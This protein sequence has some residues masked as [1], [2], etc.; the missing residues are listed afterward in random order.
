MVNTNFKKVISSILTISFLATYVFFQSPASAQS[1]QPVSIPSP[2][3]ISKIIVNSG[4]ASLEEQFSG[5]EGPKGRIVIAIQD[6]HGIFQAQENIRAVIQE[7][8]EKYHFNLVGLEGGAGKS[9]HIFLRAFPDKDASR[10]QTVKFMKR[11]ELSGGEAAAILNP[12]PGIFYG[13]ENRDL[14]FQN[15]ASFLKAMEAR[16][17]NLH[18]IRMEEKKLEKQASEIFPTE[19]YRFHQAEQKY[20]NGR[21]LFLEWLGILAGHAGVLRA[22]KYPNSFKLFEAIAKARKAGEKKPEVE[23]EIEDVTA[24]IEGRV[25]FEELNAM[26]GE[27]KNSFVAAT[28]VANN[29]AIEIATTVVATSVANNQAIEIATT[30]QQF[31]HLHL[32][33]NLISLQLTRAE[34][35]KFPEMDSRLRGNDNLNLTPALNFYVDA[36]KRD[37][38]LYENLMQAMKKENQK[39]SIIVAGG[40][41]TQGLA[42]RLK[43]EGISFAVYSPRIHEF[44]KE[45]N[46]FDVMQGKTSYSSLQAVLISMGLAD[47]VSVETF[48]KAFGLGAF[49]LLIVSQKI[50]SIKGLEAAGREWRE[51]IIKLS[52]NRTKLRDP[53]A[54]IRLAE[55]IV[56]TAAE[57]KLGRGRTEQILSIL[58][59]VFTRTLSDE[60]REKVNRFIAA[61]RTKLQ[62]KQK[63]NPEDI[64]EAVIR[65]SE[66]VVAASTSITR[67]ASLG[68]SAQSINAFHEAFKKENL[69]YE[70]RVALAENYKAPRRVRLEKEWNSWI[71][72]LKGKDSKGKEIYY[73]SA[74]IEIPP[75]SDSMALVFNLRGQKANALEFKPGEQRVTTEIRKFLVRVGAIIRDDAARRQLLLFPEP[76]QTDLPVLPKPST[77]VRGASLGV[78]PATRF[79][80][81]EWVEMPLNH[82]GHVNLRKL[83]VPDAGELPK[84]DALKQEIRKYIETY[85]KP[86][87]GLPQDINLERQAKYEAALRNLDH[88][89]LLPYMEEARRYNILLVVSRK[90]TDFKEKFIPYLRALTKIFRQIPP[91]M[92]WELA[93]PTGWEIAKTDKYSMGFQ[94]KADTWAGGGAGMTVFG[95]K[96]EELDI[97]LERVG[98]MEDLERTVGGEVRY[99][100][101]QLRKT[102]VHELLGHKRSITKKP[103]YQITGNRIRRVPKKWTLAMPRSAWQAIARVNG[104]QRI[105]IAPLQ[106]Y[107]KIEDIP[108]NPQE[109]LNL[110]RRIDE[111]PHTYYSDPLEL[112]ARSAEDDDL[113]HPHRRGAGD[114]TEVRNKRHDLARSREILAVSSA[115]IGIPVDV[116][117]KIFASWMFDAGGAE[118][119]NPYRIQYF[120]QSGPV[121]APVWQR[122]IFE[123][124]VWKI[125][126]KPV[127]LEAL[128]KAKQAPRPATAKTS[129]PEKYADPVREEILGRVA[130]FLMLKLNVLEDSEGSPLQVTGKDILGQ[131]KNLKMIRSGKAKPAYKDIRKEAGIIFAFR[132]IGLA[133]PERFRD[134]EAE[135][136]V[137]LTSEK[138]LKAA[139]GQSLGTTLEE[140]GDIDPKRW[141]GG[142]LWNELSK[143]NSGRLPRVVQVNRILPGI[144]ASG[145]PEELENIPSGEV[146]LLV[147]HYFRP[148]RNQIEHIVV[149]DYAGKIKK[150]FEKL[151]DGHVQL[152]DHFYDLRITVP[153]RVDKEARF[154]VSG[155][156]FLSK[157]S[158]GK[159]PSDGGSA[160]EMRRRGLGSEAF[161]NIAGILAGKYSG[162]QIAAFTI[163]PAVAHWFRKYF[164]AEPVA[165]KDEEDDLPCVFLGTVPDGSAPV[166]QAG[167]VRAELEVAASVSTPETSQAKTELRQFLAASFLD[168]IHVINASEKTISAETFSQLARLRDEA[169]VFQP[170][171]AYS[172]MEFLDLLVS[173]KN[174]SLKT[175]IRG[176][177]VQD[178]MAVPLHAAADRVNRHLRPIGLFID[179]IPVFTQ[180]GKFRGET[181]VYEI[182]AVRHYRVRSK[183]IDV[184]HL[185]PAGDAQYD[186]RELGM[187]HNL[188]SA[189]R[190]Y[191]DRL[192]FRKLPAILK[193]LQEDGS[194]NTGSNDLRTDRLAGEIVRRQF[195]GM[196]EGDIL[197]VMARSA[198]IHE[199]RHHLDFVVGMFDE[200]YDRGEILTRSEMSAILAEI[201]GGAHPY[202][203]AARIVELVFRREHL[204]RE[205]EDAHLNAAMEVIDQFV[206]DSARKDLKAK[207]FDFLARIQNFG[208][209]AMLRVKAESIYAGL[210]DQPSFP[211]EPVAASSLGENYFNIGILSDETLRALSDY[212]QRY[213]MKRLVRDAAML[214]NHSGYNSV[215]AD[216]GASVNADLDEILRYPDPVLRPLLVRDTQAHIQFL[217]R[218]YSYPLDSGADQK[219]RTDFRKKKEVFSRNL[220][221]LKEILRLL[222]NLP[223]DKQPSAEPGDSVEAG[224]LGKVSVKELEKLTREDW[225]GP[226]LWNVLTELNGG[227]T[228]RVIQQ[229]GLYEDSVRALEK[230]LTK[231]PSDEMTVLILYVEDPANYKMDHIIVADRPDILKRKI[232]EIVLGGFGLEAF[233][234][235]FHLSAHY[236]KSQFIGDARKSGE[237]PGL[238]PFIYLNTVSFGKRP[239]I[240]SSRRGKGIVSETFDTVVR[241][242]LEKKYPGFTIAADAA[243]LVPA[244]W[245]AKYFGARI[246]GNEDVKYRMRPYIHWYIPLDQTKPVRSFLLDPSDKE[247]LVEYLVRINANG[248][249]PADRDR[250]YKQMA[251]IGEIGNRLPAAEL[252]RIQLPAQ[253]MPET[254]VG[255]ASLGLPADRQD[256]IDQAIQGLAD[257]DLAQIDE[258]NKESTLAK[259]LDDRFKPGRGKKWAPEGRAPPQNVL[260]TGILELMSQK[261]EVISDPPAPA[262]GTPLGD[263]DLSKLNDVSRYKGYDAAAQIA[264][265]LMLAHFLGLVR[266]R[267]FRGSIAPRTIVSALKK[268]FDSKESISIGST[269]S[270]WLKI[271]RGIQTLNFSD[272]VYHGNKGQILFFE[273]VFGKGVE[274]KHLGALFTS[275]PPQVK[276]H[277]GWSMMNLNYSEVKKIRQKF[278]ALTKD[279]KAGLKGDDGQV[280]FYDS[281][282]EEDAES[283]HLGSLFSALPAGAAREM[284]WSLLNL[285]YK[286]ENALYTA[287][288]RLSEQEKGTFTGD[289]GQIAF[290]EMVFG[291]KV[292]GKHLSALFSVFSP[293]VKERMDWTMIRLNY[294]EVKNLRDAFD[295]LTPEER[296]HFKGDEGQIKFYEL[297]FAP[298]LDGKFLANLYSALPKGA[299]KEMGWSNISLNYGDVRRLREASL[300]RLEELKR[301]YNSLEGQRRLYDEL[302][303]AEKVSRM[304]TRG[305]FMALPHEVH[306]VMTN[307][308]KRFD[309]TISDEARVPPAFGGKTA[310]G[311][312][313]GQAPA[314]SSARDQARKLID[315]VRAANEPVKICFVCDAN[316]NRSPAMQLLLESRAPKAGIGDL[317]ISSGGFRRWTQEVIAS[318]LV[319]TSGSFMARLQGRISVQRPELEEK[320]IQ[321]IAKNNA[322]ILR[323]NRKGFLEAKFS[324]VPRDLVDFYLNYDT[325]RAREWIDSPLT[326]DKEAYRKLLAG[327]VPEL[328]E[329]I[330]R[331]IP[332]KL[333]PDYF[334]FQRNDSLIEALTR[335]LPAYDPMRR[336]IKTFSSRPVTRSQVDAST[337]VIA[338]DQPAKENIERI[339]PQAKGK[340]FLFTELAPDAFKNQR[341]VP[342]PAGYEITKQQL[343]AG[344][345]RGIERNL[346][347]LLARGEAET[348]PAPAALPVTGA[349]LG[350][351]PPAGRAGAGRQGAINYLAYRLG[352]G[353]FEGDEEAVKR[354]LA[355]AITL[356]NIDSIGLQIYVIA[357]NEAA[358]QSRSAA[359]LLRRFVPRNEG[360]M[361]LADELMSQSVFSQMSPRERRR[362][363]R[364]LR[365]MFIGALEGASLEAIRAKVEEDERGRLQALGRYGEAMRVKDGGP[366]MQ[367]ALA[368]LSADLDKQIK[369]V[370]KPQEKFIFAAQAESLPQSESG[371]KELV[372][373]TFE[374]VPDDFMNRPLIDWIVYY[375]EGGSMRLKAIKNYVDELRKNGQHDWTG[376]IALKRKT[377]R[378]L[379]SAFRNV[380]RMKKPDEHLIFIVPDLSRVQ[381]LIEAHVMEH[382]D[383]NF[384]TEIPGM[385]EVLAKAMVAL[386]WALDQPAKDAAAEKLLKDLEDKLGI[387]AK[388]DEKSRQVIVTVNLSVFIDRIISLQQA[389]LAVMRAA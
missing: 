46:Y 54:L 127:D 336:R 101:D 5:P 94:G 165:D 45:N 217:K 260:L 327:P 245:F 279:A 347:P 69:P 145:I 148:G 93:E 190:V 115:R 220:E 233:E 302:F 258:S 196:T 81:G 214:I 50:E 177:F 85:L 172:I 348:P 40:F 175:G 325:A 321:A 369:S 113:A 286:D 385:R 139:A 125:V 374:S 60:A 130:Y 268:V 231:T 194:Y 23:K 218:Q 24:K 4:A 28:S 276:E 367:R 132:S 264:R 201:A 299:A 224:S 74:F 44:E 34:Y 146:V 356:E 83:L 112:T 162:S 293:E 120:R 174:Q 159:R 242:V 55:T 304:D 30:I 56:R 114:R 98:G 147:L 284:G 207:A 262:T 29:Q 107:I 274:K 210:F 249:T 164:S 195:E 51:H 383:D 315:Q 228:P 363:A 386:A 105:V 193:S 136:V 243:D 209:D 289:V 185:E 310:Q 58:E 297:V 365:E 111:H 282:F 163:H 96:P 267:S 123:N 89:V 366:A 49:D 87:P 277:L 134:D 47:T 202:F 205:S 22:E 149:A 240:I 184:L 173:A 291:E 216:R 323:M 334:I 345:L 39:I 179:F 14:Y 52:K 189:A 8:Q 77:A 234:Y 110:L 21:M 124:D 301:S 230:K 316:Y 359:G 265:D 169:A 295:H 221:K 68:A 275:V 278:A 88:P 192:K 261:L 95:I 309:G 100:E 355:D 92:F 239:V 379:S 290:Y 13:L 229:T 241:S 364:K 118:K 155:P 20:L 126:G 352:F 79:A 43:Q 1:I 247:N 368:K 7:L 212:G 272:P 300:G 344:V 257:F 248:K 156:L 106:H 198:E 170:E 330:D 296:K 314:A 141:T 250:L 119:G 197:G 281:I 384:E 63:L 129:R 237:G 31:H 361:H 312:S 16:D 10:E 303:G 178:Q 288:N 339:F 271:R 307:W 298:K 27:I 319:T 338:A 2:I 182:K 41:H 203:S 80:R 78:S 90:V 211:A 320:L 280:T 305:A 333:A 9:D 331:A 362:I 372:E 128:A 270:D 186:R 72:D 133:D 154:Q 86:R 208:N 191:L 12:K 346:I 84:G 388:R 328:W 246:A 35:E 306:R 157:I 308:K 64:D 108:Q 200:E 121:E 15:R 318:R 171:F 82:Y 33:K 103:F 188:D 187:A 266:I 244:Y 373:S 116:K 11:A 91:E 311:A 36:V 343:S 285:S 152:E 360:A 357:R 42:T 161:R 341:G 358:K 326:P 168:F 53:D 382:R 151:L 370:M 138:L 378:E 25:L 252:A 38:A 238:E 351:P 226:K 70:V 102:V 109:L 215:T 283:K 225:I 18:A 287:Y 387:S 273:K 144:Y 236:G 183:T 340:V 376:R 19:L 32:L 294:S 223:E 3:D 57:R 259:I 180:E 48:E 61:L 389:E 99:D 71:I 17:A 160:F 6:A 332:G 219:E 349:S 263:I 75:K 253:S 150:D 317:M 176:V 142:P 251:V 26:A 269:V 67:A 59:Q 254:G 255:A 353:A 117:E 122:V 222:Q 73:G 104:L 380:Q 350:L 37:Q 153:V 381:S 335:D 65:S 227:K 135:F 206:P 137:R 371:M 97:P 292:Q 322:G 131:M 158:L 337:L 342:D 143:I 181:Y 204:A 213:E 166:L 256:A 375:T 199:V 329:Q 324:L 354:E 76:A 313:L 66:F 167:P 62:E 235:E 377:P 140:M 232:R